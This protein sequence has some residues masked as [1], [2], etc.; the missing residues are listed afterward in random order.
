MPLPHK[1]RIRV[2]YFEAKGLSRP[3]AVQIVACEFN[4]R[5]LAVWDAVNDDNNW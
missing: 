3:S 1:L 2:A 4:V 5:Q